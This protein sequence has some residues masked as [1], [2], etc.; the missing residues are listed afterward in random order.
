[1]QLI[2]QIV[3][4]SQNIGKFAPV[5][6]LLPHQHQTSC[7]FDLSKTPIHTKCYQHVAKSNIT[8]CEPCSSR[9]SMVLST[10]CS[11]IWPNKGTSRACGN[12]NVGTIA[13]AIVLWLQVC[14]KQGA[15][16]TVIELRTWTLVSHGNSM[17]R[18]EYNEYCSHLH[19]GASYVACLQA[20]LKWR[21]ISPSHTKIT[22]WKHK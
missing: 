21:G 22:L 15:V 7:P 14:T 11:E 19:F 20:L 13:H 17:V 9:I 8:E 2:H 4:N 18:Y 6:W 16:L 10:V 1:M 5:V 12:L 3:S